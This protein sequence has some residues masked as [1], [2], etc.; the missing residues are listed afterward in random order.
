M[1]NQESRDIISPRP[2]GGG[3]IKTKSRITNQIRSNKKKKKR[4]ELQSKF[5]V[6]NVMLQ[7]CNPYG[8]LLPLNFRIELHKINVTSKVLHYI[9]L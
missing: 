9:I 6:M 3:D 2:N 8:K 1:I 4:E 7:R 5:F